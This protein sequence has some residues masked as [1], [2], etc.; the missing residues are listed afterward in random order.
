[1]VLIFWA[2]GSHFTQLPT[3]FHQAS[4]DFHGSVTALGFAPVAFLLLRAYSMGGGTYTGIEAVSNGVTMLR[5][6]RVKTGKRTMF[7]MAT[8]LAFTAGGILFAYM[9]VDDHPDRDKTLNAV[10]LERLFTGWHL[11]S[12]HIGPTFV[13]A[14][15]IAEAALLFVAA[16]TGFLDGPRILSN[17]AVDSWM[18]HRFAQLSNRLVTQ[19]GVF[20]MGFAAVATLIYTRGD[21]AT[22]LVM[23]SINVFLTFSLTELGMTRHSI[24]ERAR[25]PRWKRRLA[26]HGT[27]LVL[28]VSILCVTIYEK[29]LQGG[30]ITIVCTGAMIVLC[31]VIRRHY[32]TTRRALGHLDRELTSLPL[33][34]THEPPPPVDPREPTAVITVAGFSGFGLHELLSINQLFPRHFKNFVFA[35]V[36]VVDSGN[37]KGEGA[38]AEL[39]EE[40]RAS[41]ERY[42]EWCRAHGLRSAWR[43]STGTEA[44][45]TLESLC[46]EVAA[47]FPRAVFFGGKLVFKEERWYHRI[48]HNET[49]YALQRRLQFA[50]LPTIILPIRVIERAGERTGPA[51]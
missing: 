3:I 27:G 12:L 24:I 32:Q 30:W 19:N 18:P 49:G 35:S 29:F 41:L 25:E 48:L 51:A 37:F 38:V 2:I 7:L 44:V 20:L 9:L 45:G 14:T 46:R 11:G 23:Y 47:E 22:L 1:V 28:C 6:P 10:L 34:N 40:T 21:I 8:S 42:V 17:M 39:E 43:M 36:A 16:Q 5:E 4:I 15:L 31:F 13:V 26:L 33:P 50:G